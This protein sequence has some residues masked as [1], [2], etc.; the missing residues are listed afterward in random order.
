MNTQRP[1][2]DPASVEQPLTNFSQ[3]HVGITRQLQVLSELPALLEPAA[4]ARRIA[5]ETVAFLRSTV[6]E[7]HSEEERELFPAV[8]AAATRGSE[9]E[10]VQVLVDRLVAEH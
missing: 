6:H 2:P 4:K 9:R 10:G 3:C 8:L 5:R 1:T 7:H